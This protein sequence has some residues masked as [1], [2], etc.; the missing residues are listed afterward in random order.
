MF[1]QCY[2]P[3]TGDCFTCF[4]YQNLSLLLV[5]ATYTGFCSI[6]KLSHHLINNIQSPVSFLYLYYYISVTNG[7]I[8]E[9]KGEEAVFFEQN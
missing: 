4:C 9:E 2:V 7:L 3:G 6:L 5:T 1:A 8:L